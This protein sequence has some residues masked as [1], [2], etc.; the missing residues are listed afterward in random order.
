[1]V[2]PAS[3]WRNATMSFSSAAA[4]FRALTRNSRSLPRKTAS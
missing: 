1:M 4:A 3:S 2:F